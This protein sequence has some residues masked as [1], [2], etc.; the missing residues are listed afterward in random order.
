MKY[1][2]F[3]L[4]FQ[5]SQLIVAQS[6]SEFLPISPFEGVDDSVIAFSDVDNDGDQDIFITG[7]AGTGGSSQSTTALYINEG[8]NFYEITPSPFPILDSPYPSPKI[9][10]FDFDGD[11]DEDILISGETEAGNT[12]F[13]F[14]TNDGGTFTEV[15]DPLI[16]NFYEPSFDISDID[17]D[18]DMDILISG[19][20]SNLS[21]DD[22][23]TKLYR[24]EGGSFTEVMDT[25]FED[26]KNTI[27]FFDMDGDNDEDVLITNHFS[28]SVYTFTSYENN[29]GEFTEKDNIYFFSYITPLA[30][31]DVDGDNDKDV[32]ISQNIW[33][34]VCRREHFDS[35]E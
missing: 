16:E 35:Y 26:K 1:F 32:I 4:L 13:T 28:G 27:H 30:I 24:N 7:Q 25:P 15:S 10:F 14:Y 2:L 21:G 12:I 9:V 18:N 23:V 20:P 6:F 31:S 5:F 19:D 3:I 29:G 17:G 8:E 22:Y 33:R 11:N 34:R